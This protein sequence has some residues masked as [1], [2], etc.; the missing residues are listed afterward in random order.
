MGPGLRVLKMWEKISGSRFRGSSVSPDHC[1]LLTTSDSCDTAQEESP[2]R[3]EVPRSSSDFPK[4]RRCSTAVGRGCLWGRRGPRRPRSSSEGPKHAG[5]WMCLFSGT[6]GMPDP[7]P[8]PAWHVLG[9][10]RGSPGPL[11][12][13]ATSCCH[14]VPAALKL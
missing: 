5:L 12:N 3:P 13:P 4:V 11:P 6:A 1:R 2:G 8:G 7:S 9:Q 14:P 10:R